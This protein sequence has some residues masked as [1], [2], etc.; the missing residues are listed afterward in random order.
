M[1]K[2]VLSVNSISSGTTM[3]SSSIVSDDLSDLET[4]AERGRLLRVAKG[5]EESQKGPEK[6]CD[7]MAFEGR[8]K[9]CQDSSNYTMVR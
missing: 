3:L 5:L 4:K 6:V 1:G 7:T 2:R 8:Q 9:A